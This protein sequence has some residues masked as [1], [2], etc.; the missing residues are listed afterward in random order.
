MKHGGPRSA[1]LV[2]NLGSRSTSSILDEAVA[3]LAE[4]GIAVEAAVGVES[5]AELRERVARFV[6]EGAPLIAVAGGDGSLSSIVG[7][8]SH[9]ES[10]LGV[11]PAGTGN[12]FART[13][14]IRPTVEDA[15]ATIVSGKVAHVDLG[16]ANGTSFANFATVGLAAR[17][18][19]QTPFTLKR[20]A[21][22]A[23]YVL[24][25]IPLM[26]RS[27]PFRARIR[28]DDAEP[29]E[30]VTHQIVV[31]NGR[32]YGVVPLLPEATIVD[33]RLKLAATAT[34]SAWGAARLF[35]AIHLGRQRQLSDG[36]FRIAR[37]ITIETFPP[38]LLDVDGETLGATPARFTVDRGALS[39]MVPAEFDGT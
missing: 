30:I 15:V 34:T 5:G 38:Q 32:H 22:A 23:A 35:L 19:R 21:G 10:V 7:L 25:T 27:R 4:G 26:L 37:Q 6:G 24:S 13:L 3:R 36:L 12:S 14:G 2:G 28:F 8:F 17:V 16:I 18:A 39:V 20:V 33:G 11:I 9:R 1:V 31:V 29:I